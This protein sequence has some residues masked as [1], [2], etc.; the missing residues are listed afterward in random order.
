MNAFRDACLATGAKASAVIRDLCKAAVPYMADNCRDGRWRP[1]VLITERQAA[2]L[3]AR[4]EVQQVVTGHRNHVR[5]V[6]K[7][8]KGKLRAR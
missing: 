3:D 4:P 5:Q 1:P 2:A 6:A 8:R 7:V